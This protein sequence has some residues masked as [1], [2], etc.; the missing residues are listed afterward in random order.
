[1][2]ALFWHTEPKRGRVAFPAACGMRDHERVG[3]SII[4]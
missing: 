3:H 4:A 2:K 1:M